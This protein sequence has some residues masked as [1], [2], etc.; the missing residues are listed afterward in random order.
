MMGYYDRM[1][2]KPRTGPRT[3][4]ADRPHT[5]TILLSALGVLVAGAGIWINYQAS[6]ARQLTP[7]E[8]KTRDIIPMIPLY[9]NFDVTSSDGLV[10]VIFGLGRGISQAGVSYY[11]LSYTLQDRPVPEAV[12][13]DRLEAIAKVEGLANEHAV[14]ALANRGL[15]QSQREYLIDTVTAY[16]KKLAPGT[17]QDGRLQALI[18][19]VLKR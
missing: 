9:L 4:V 18:R 1:P 6:K 12:F 19:G 14:L 8:F 17:E 10:H 5:V 16:A 7:E 15:T 2:K 3:K 13:Q 11:E